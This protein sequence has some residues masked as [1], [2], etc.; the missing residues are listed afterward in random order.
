MAAA[1]F[2]T[3]DGHSVEIF[4]RCPRPLPVGA[5]LLLQPTGLACLARLGLR[6]QA[7][8]HGARVERVDGLTTKG[9][10]VFDVAYRDLGEQY[11]GLGVHRG[12]LFTI[13]LEEVQRL[14]IPIRN[15][16]GIV[17]T[18]LKQ[19][20]RLLR[21]SSREDLGPFDLVVD[22][23]GMRSPPRHHGSVSRNKLYPYAALWG[24]VDDPGQAF[25]GKSLHQRYQGAQT[26]IGLLPIGREPGG[27][28]EQC[29]F[30]WSLRSRDHQAWL[31]NDLEAWKEQVVRCWPEIKPLLTQL[32]AHDDLTF[33]EYS[34]SVMKP[35]HTDR[36]VFIGD[37]AHCTS[38]QLGQGANLALADAFMLSGAL[39]RHEQIDE[40]LFAYNRSRL[41]HTRFY[42]IAS[43]W[44]TPFFQSDSNMAGWLRDLTFAKLCKT[45]YIRT[46]M[47]RT[48]AGVKNGWFSHMALRDWIEDSR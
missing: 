47:L 7:M 46:E 43:R 15:G 40:A 32:A 14:G 35:W 27:T 19:D 45:P 30:F 26:M 12:A 5:G 33:A 24:L 13:L 2:L 41:A 28:K 4:E 23:S 8:D 22:A 11:F 20:R 34:D 42:Q 31:E 25:G 16:C 18:R 9:R 29:A 10:V 17:D 38:P 39:R 6:Q 44:L 37:A 1:A 21:S 3:A 48:L 36:L